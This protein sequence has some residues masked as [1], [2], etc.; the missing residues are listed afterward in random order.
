MKCH[1]FQYCQ[2]E[3]QTKY[4]GLDVCKGHEDTLE[5]EKHRFDDERDYEREQEHEDE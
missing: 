4:D 3:A 5:Y 1:Y 2:K